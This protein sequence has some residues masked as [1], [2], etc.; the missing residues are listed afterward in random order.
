MSLDDL[1]HKDVHPIPYEQ[2]CS[3]E[4]ERI[5][6]KS[7]KVMNLH[8]IQVNDVMINC[9]IMKRKKERFL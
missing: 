1:A 3:I 2:V 9:Y 5:P 8:N 6:Q 7:I 4:T